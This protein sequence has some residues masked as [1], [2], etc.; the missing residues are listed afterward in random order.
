MLRQPIV[1][2]AGHIDHGKTSLLDF[3]RKTA[4]VASEAGGITQCISCS[5]LSIDI[6]KNICGELLTNLKM[7]LS[8]PGLLFI[9]T[10]GHA[11]FNN[12]RKRGGNLADIA[13]LVV[14]I[15]EGFKPQ[16]IETIEILKTYKTPFVVAANKIDIIPGWEKK[17]G[18][19]LQEINSQR[20]DVRQLVEKRIYEL[21]GKIYEHGFNSER[22]DRVEDFTKQIAIVPLSAMTGEGIPSLLMVLVGLAQRFLE[23]SLNLDINGPAKGTILEVKEETGL[24]KVM[25]T[26]IYDGKLCVNDAIVVGSLD[27]P[28]VSKVRALLQQDC[29]ER[30]TRYKNVKSV[31][32]AAGVKISAPAIE[33][34]LAG[35]PIMSSSKDKLEETKEKILEEIEEVVIHTETEGIAVKADTLG[36]LEALTNVLKEKNIPV[37]SA[38]IGNITKKDIIDAQA[39]MDKDPLKGV[40][41]GF[42]SAAEPG[43]DT[44]NVKVISNNIIYRLIEEF[45]AWKVEQQKAIQQKEID[46]LV[47]PCKIELLKGYVFRQNNPAVCGV[48]ITLGSLRPGTPLMGKE[49]RQLTVV[50]SIQSENENVSKAERGKQVAVS[51]PDVTI[52]RQIQEGDILYSAIP[53]EDFRKLK[54]LKQYLSKDEVEAIKEIVKMMREKNPVWGV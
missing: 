38:S 19:I 24:G 1:V 15:N 32:A 46:L 35:M 27:K 37:N 2:V 14:D 12:M 44:K 34:A 53:E 9:D 41:L 22:F 26:I 50:K 18:H 11:A 40:I 49:G 28:V 30:K 45:E 10:P 31:F 17:E 43:L 5:T 6:L 29:C 51:M 39:N 8:V 52:G 16:T 21:V 7:K 42:N 36:S 20:D 23:Q 13:I 48:E 47:R 4:V 25:D 54:G 33:G 3:I